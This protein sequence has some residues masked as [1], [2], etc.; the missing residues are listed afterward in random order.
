METKDSGSTQ[1]RR[2]GAADVSV[3]VCVCVCVLGEEGSVGERLAEL[4]LLPPW[5][6]LRRGENRAEHGS[7]PPHN[8]GP[9][10]KAWQKQPL[11]RWTEQPVSQLVKT[12]GLDT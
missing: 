10:M 9:I 8:Q 5:E 4:V 3:C 1:G 2:P 7:Q 12:L 11:T 6:L